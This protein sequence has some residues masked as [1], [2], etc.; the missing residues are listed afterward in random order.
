MCYYRRKDTGFFFLFN[1]AKAAGFLFL[2]IMAKVFRFFLFLPRG[3][4]NSQMALF[5]RTPRDFSHFLFP[6]SRERCEVSQT[7]DDEL[8]FFWL[9]NYVIRGAISWRRGIGTA[10]F[11]SELLGTSSVLCFSFRRD[12]ESHNIYYTRIKVLAIVLKKHQPP[13]HSFLG[14][15]L[16]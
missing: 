16:V 15:K 9:I 2:E 14:K 10:V 7:R 3:E 6:E 5:G 12:S 1:D 4:S 11:W 13:H 8:F